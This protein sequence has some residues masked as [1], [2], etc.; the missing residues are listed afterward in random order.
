[1]PVVVALGH[2]R[3]IA[4]RVGAIV[5]IL[6]RVGLVIPIVRGT[7]VGIG[8]VIIPEIGRREPSQPN[9]E[10]AATAAEAMVKPAAMEPAGVKPATVETTAGGVGGPGA[11]VISTGTAS[12]TTAMFGA[13]DL[14]PAKRGDEQQSRSNAPENLPDFGPRCTAAALVHRSLHS[15]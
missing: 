1:L 7:I 4:G 9:R 5:P 15:N 8:V 12:S 6:R 11:P 10:A 3:I 13:G 2:V 14:R